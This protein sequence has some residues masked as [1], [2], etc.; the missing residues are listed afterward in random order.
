MTWALIAVG[1]YFIGSIPFGLLI[2]RWVAGVDLRAVGSGNIGATNA[3]R[4]VGK[5]WGIIVLLLD[6][7][8]GL[9]PTA[10]VPLVFAVEPTQALHAS[11][12]AGMCAILGHTFPVWLKFR[13]GKGVATALGVA[14]VLSPLGTLTAFGA[15][16]I[17]MLTARI[18]SLGS[19]VA[20]VAFATYQH[21][22][23]Q[24]DPWSASKW[25]LATFSVAIPALIIIRHRENIR[26][27]LRGEEARWKP[28]SKDAPK[29][30]QG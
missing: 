28:R 4:V 5:T 25:S 22:A 23:M 18:V 30:A 17:V 10:F 15:F 3:S 7:L 6:A 19:I 12:L 26:R 11:V 27:L 14:V 21:F 9:L 24:P 1:S 8:K 20:A 13:G 16:V 2:A 29:D